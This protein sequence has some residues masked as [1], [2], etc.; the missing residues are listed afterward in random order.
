MCILI[1]VVVILSYSVVLYV[2]LMLVKLLIVIGDD[3]VKW[4][5]Y[6]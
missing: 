1:G 3:I 2:V 6:Y 4:V 5:C